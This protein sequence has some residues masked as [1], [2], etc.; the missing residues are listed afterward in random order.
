M[1]PAYPRDTPIAAAIFDEDREASRGRTFWAKTSSVSQAGWVEGSH[2]EHA[3]AWRRRVALCLAR[4]SEVCETNRP[5]RAASARRWVAPSI[6][7]LPHW[8]LPTLI[9]FPH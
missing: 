6:A 9:F 8:V 4:A 1:R 2:S 5:I 3:C 7:H